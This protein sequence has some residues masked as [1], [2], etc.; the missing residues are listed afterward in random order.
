MVRI[1]IATLVGTAGMIGAV[2]LSPPIDGDRLLILA[3]VL[4]VGFVGMVGY[5]VAAYLLRIHEV[6]AA[7]T[8]VRSKLRSGRQA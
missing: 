6:T 3:T 2:R 8:L 5:L 4:A 1:V 7:F